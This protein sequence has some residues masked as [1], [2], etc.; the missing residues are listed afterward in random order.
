[1]IIARE[2]SIEEVKVG[3]FQMILILLLG[4]NYAIVAMSHALPEIHN[5][6]PTKFHCDSVSVV[7]ALKKQRNSLAI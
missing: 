7:D 5:Y 4:I 1:M 2:M 6:T 3:C